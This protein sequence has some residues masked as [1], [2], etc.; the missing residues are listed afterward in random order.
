MFSKKYILIIFFISL[1]VCCAQ[2]K[3]IG[4]EKD[5]I[6]A[7]IGN[8]YN[9]TFQDLRQYFI[10]WQYNIKYRNRNI[11]AGYKE[12]LNSLIENQMKRIDFFSRGL[13]KNKDLMKSMNRIINE[14]MRVDY[15]N[16]QLNSKYVNEKKAREVY[17]VM[18]KEVIY[19]QIVLPLHGNEK[20]TTLDSLNSKA[21]QIQTD[22]S[23]TKDIVKY[24]KKLSAKNAAFGNLNKINW[25]QSVTDPVGSVVFNLK[26][27]FTRI[28]KSVD[29]FYIVKVTDIKK[30]K[31]EPFEKMKNEIMAKLKNVYFPIFED[32]FKNEMKESVD[33]GTLKWNENGLAKIAEW[34]NIPRFYLSAYEDTIQNVIK[35]GGNFEILSYHNGSVDL[36]EYLHLLDDVL[37]MNPEEEIDNSKI[38][39]FIL[40]AVRDENVIKEARRVIT[41]SD[42]FNP[43]TK[44][45]VLRYRIAV[46]YNKAMIE[47]QIPEATEEALLKFYE[48]HKNSIFYQLQVKYIHARI[49]TDS[50]KAAN[51][52]KEINKGIP[53]EK[54]SNSWYNKSFVRE[55]DGELKS[56]FS[57]EPP[58]LAKAAFK[59]NLNEV[60][61][62]IEYTDTSNVKNYAVIKCVNI[63]PEKQL[64]YDDVKNKIK[65][66]FI[67]Y[68]REKIS[69]EVDL[70]LRKKYKVEIFYNVLSNVLSSK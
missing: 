31:L 57:T 40:E 16:E 17:N 67:D 65:E 2:S 41:E 13:N 4:D 38:K 18:D 68:Y 5:T 39:K 61:G 24:L 49:Y 26:K 23:K 21:I 64:T 66:K 6:V 20:K 62:P 47:N 1:N 52:M 14:E 29:G 30:I 10:D 34:S 7:K 27:G 63:L 53:F 44:N 56:Y 54:I 48:E 69:K 3:L 33:E 37:I 70:Q 42:I 11:Y 46:Q 60:A 59:L 25:E 55:K 32:E 45:A 36:K 19:Y 58:Y 8:D 51:E 43:Y 28:I 22:I 15:F 50:V 35:N 9:V 12:A